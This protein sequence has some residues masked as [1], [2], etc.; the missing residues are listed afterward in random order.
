MHLVFVQGDSI[1]AV[2]TLGS[3][4]YRPSSPPPPPPCDGSPS[5]HIRAPSLP[6]SMALLLPHTAPPNAHTDTTGAEP[7]AGYNA[8]AHDAYSNSSNELYKPLKSFSKYGSATVD[9]KP[10]GFLR[11]KT[12]FQHCKESNTNGQRVDTVN[13]LSGNTFVGNKAGNTAC[14]IPCRKSS[15]TAIDDVIMEESEAHDT[16]G[17]GSRNSVKTTATTAG[18][19]YSYSNNHRSSQSSDEMM[20]TSSSSFVFPSPPPPLPPGPP[21]SQF[22]LGELPPPPGV[23]EPVYRALSNPSDAGDTTPDSCDMDAEPIYFTIPN[24]DLPEEQQQH[25]AKV[26]LSMNPANTSEHGSSNGSI[27]RSSNGSIG[28]SS[29]SSVCSIKRSSNGSLNSNGSNG[30]YGCDT[31]AIVCKGNRLLRGE[32]RVISKELTSTFK[33]VETSM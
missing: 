25:M 24:G 3:S 18:V 10:N 21:S 29:N 16:S 22:Q 30:L 4:A 19:V 27:G 9:P 23:T 17:R 2:P 13:S 5:Q 1:Y 12:P 6:A 28:R 7:T 31:V 32:V 20:E 14:K 8:F 33:P 26:L 11:M 15:T